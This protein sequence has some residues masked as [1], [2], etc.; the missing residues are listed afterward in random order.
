MRSRLHLSG[1]FRPSAATKGVGGGAGEA[2]TGAT[3]LVP[4]GAR[5]RE[6]LSTTSAISRALP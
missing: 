5:E 2:T 1:S 4:G 6:D 3:W